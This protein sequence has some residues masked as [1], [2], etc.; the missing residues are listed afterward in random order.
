MCTAYASMRIA[1]SVFRATGMCI[2]IRGLPRADQGFS[3]FCGHE[4]SAARP[5][6]APPR[7]L[8]HSP[9]GRPRAFPIPSPQPVGDSE[10]LPMRVVVHS[11]VSQDRDGARLAL[12]RTRR[13][14]PWLEP[15]WADGGYNAW[16]VRLVSCS[17]GGKGAV[18]APGDRQAKRRREELR[19][20]AA[21]SGGRA[22]LFLVR[23]QPASGQGFREPCPNPGPLRDPR[24]HTAGPQAAG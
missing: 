18:A 3:E 17:G 10:W 1:R 24:L 22:N 13:R 4:K 12:S 8:L 11:A 23:T 16:Q 7:F 6:R 9:S 5:V 20:P 21:P 15:I 14:F 2:P 19:R